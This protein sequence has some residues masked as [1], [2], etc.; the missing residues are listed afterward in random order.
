MN[1]A[2]AF[3][4]SPYRPPTSYP[5]TLDPSEAAAWL[6]AHF[7]LWHPAVLA[8]LDGP[9][10]AASAY[11]HD[12]PVD[13]AVYA[14][15][16]GPHLYQASD[17]ADRVKTVGA[18]WFEATA[19]LAETRHAILT[20]LRERHPDAGR[21]DADAETVRLFAAVGY[22]HLLVEG[23]FDA[24]DH[25]HL[26]D[27]D[28][29]WANVTA[30]LAEPADARTHLTD[31]A[32]KLRDARE[33]LSSQAI[34]LLDWALPDGTKPDAAWPGTLTRGLPLTVIASVDVLRKLAP[35][36]LAELRA[37]CPAGLPATVDF[38]C[39]SA[40]ERDDSYLP[41]ESQ[42]WNLAA[43]RAGVHE[44][45]GVTPTIVGRQRSAYH[46]LCPAWWKH[47]GYTAGMMVPL[48]EALAPNRNAAVLNW[49]APDGTAID[50]LGREPLPA[51][52]PLTFFN[53]VYTLHNAI[54]KDSRPTV[55]FSHT[56]EPPAI[57]YDE[58]LTLADL[59]TAVGEFTG[60]AR[61]LADNHYGDY[62]GTVT[63][64]DFFN[65]PL[66]RRVGTEKRSDPVSGFARHL[67]L[68]RQLDTA[69]ALLALYRVLTP[70]SVDDES[71]FAALDAL[72]AEIETRGPD[73]AESPDP[74]A[75]RAATAERAAAERLATRLQLN[76][77]GGPAGYLVLNPC[78]FTR[79]AALEIADFG[80]PIEVKDALK[81]A[82]FDGVAAK[83]VVEVPALGFAWVPKPDGTATAPKPRFKS[84]DG[85]I[86][87]NEFFEAELDPTTGGLR[88]FRDMRTRINRLGMQP[89]FN[90]GSRSRCTKLSLGSNGTALGEITAEGEITD[91]HDA[92]LAKFT[93]RLR[94]WAGRP[95]LELVLEI[96]PVH[97]PTGYAWHAYYGARFGWRDGRAAIFRGVQGMNQQST[98]AR[99]VSPDYFEVRMGGE[100]TFVFTGGLPFLQKH[101]SRMLDVV[102]IPEGETTRRFEFLLACDRDYPMQTAQ[103]WTTPTPVV[104]TA[105]GPPG[106]VASSWLAALDLPSVLLTSLRP[107]PGRSVC[108]RLQETAGFGGT[109][110]LR[111][112][113]PPVSATTIDGPGEPITPVTLIGNAVPLEF[114]AHETFRVRAEW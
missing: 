22:G 20:A 15:P 8:R 61:Y 51:G 60:T 38:A 2:P 21:L 50:A 13:G 85:N 112:A 62:L 11:D 87:R 6:A 17:W 111:F 76:T 40:V 56:G 19:D 41:A 114:S 5:V 91:E 42:F 110:D 26:L 86:V 105:K 75:E 90:P 73:I 58:L 25:E 106:G 113:V 9:P 46:P 66:D 89:V 3:L 83:L 82:Q 93:H 37:K 64:D 4:L 7:A 63:G 98:Y 49:P 35:D 45:F 47:A 70:P 97:A 69:A 80:G 33:A 57:G 84:V 68:R 99:P 10:V 29:F 32:A 95:A 67:R 52:D 103:G 14:V 24:A 36:R 72:E 34:A 100:R 48:D 59:S 74:L 102:L 39:G 55:V 18:V 28:G 108:A 23:L 30:A 88:S 44:L 107:G 65:D 12:T 1:H 54:T 27:R 31:A 92:V 77:P 94:A 71:Q 109:C 96:D 78:A 81:A 16:Q 79:R 104:P 101:E 53:L 43:A